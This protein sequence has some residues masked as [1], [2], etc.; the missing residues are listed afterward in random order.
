MVPG[1]DV[2]RHIPV[3]VDPVDLPPFAYRPGAD[4]GMEIPHAL[5]ARSHVAMVVMKVF[6]LVFKTIVMK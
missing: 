4:A 6:G 1:Q 2:F 3:D 5:V